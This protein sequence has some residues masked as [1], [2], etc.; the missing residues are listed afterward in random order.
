LERV[1]I[2]TNMLRKDRRPSVFEDV[3]V[4]RALVHA[5]DTKALADAIYFGQAKP[6]A[7]PIVAST[8]PY[9]DTKFTPLPFD[10]AKAKSLLAEARLPASFEPNLYAPTD[11]KELAVLLVSFWQQAGFKVKLNLL[12]P[13]SLSTAWYQRK[14]EGDHIILAR[15]LANGMP[16]LVYLDPEAQVAAYSG[17][18]TAA[19]VRQG[20]AILDNAQQDKWLREVFSPAINHIY[21]IPALLEHPEGVFG[22]GRR[23]KSWDRFDLHGM[24]FQ[25]LVPTP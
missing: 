16:S 7:L 3:R 15:L 24:G 25:W 2:F 8:L 12:D 9:F 10:L 23:V 6:A 4:R 17:A 14:L 19:L 11:S 13:S 18:E 1:L 22:L 20:Y 5:V 21:P